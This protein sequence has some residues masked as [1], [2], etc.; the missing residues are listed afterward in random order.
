[1][2]RAR[3]ENLVAVRVNQVQQGSAAAA[4]HATGGGL[5]NPLECFLA[6]FGRT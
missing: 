3:E 4:E 2:E 1:V 5:R 6:Q